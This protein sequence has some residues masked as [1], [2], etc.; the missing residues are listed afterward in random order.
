M[1][2]VVAFHRAPKRRFIPGDALPAEWTAGAA[3]A[4]SAA[5]AFDSDAAGVAVWLAE[6]KCVLAG[7]QT[8]IDSEE[9]MLGAVDRLT[10]H[11]KRLRPVAGSQNADVGV[12]GGVVVGRRA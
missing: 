1:G 12:G 8:D 4:G 6:V 10:I 2:D 5:L 11:I 3:A 7:L 9:T